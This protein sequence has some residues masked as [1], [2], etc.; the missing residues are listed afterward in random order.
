MA[1]GECSDA[2]KVSE[3]NGVLGLGSYVTF[4][5]AEF[6]A[7]SLCGKSKKYVKA[8]EFNG[9][10]LIRVYFANGVVYNGNKKNDRKDTGVKGDC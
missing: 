9:E 5:A 3:K 7:N 6:V 10:K 4:I 1:A 8:V 2:A